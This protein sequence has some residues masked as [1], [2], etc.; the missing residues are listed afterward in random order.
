M[1]YFAYGSNMHKHDME[2]RC[3]FASP[4]GAWTL[5][6]HKI[7]FSYGVAD[8]VPRA[9]NSVVGVLWEITEKDELNL[10]HYESFPLLYG[11]H[12]HD[13]VMFYRMN[14]IDEE[15]VDVL[16][17]PPQ[18]YLDTMLSGYDQFGIDRTSFLR[19]M[20]LLSVA[21]AVS[22]YRDEEVTFGR[23]AELANIHPES[24]LA[25]LSALRIRR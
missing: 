1:K 25:L 20:G 2:F 11:K 18:Y 22:Q 21:D 6:N 9:D 24:F 17:I 3:P 13:D 14:D 12:W 23:A 8:V 5:P 10:D 4:I 16:A 19:N 15:C 7:Y